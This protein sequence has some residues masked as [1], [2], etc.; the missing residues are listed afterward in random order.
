[1]L[2]AKQKKE[3]TGTTKKWLET[4][5]IGL[6]L[7]PFAK[8]PYLRGG[9]RLTVEEA[10]SM[11]K[12]LQIFADEVAFLQKNPATDT[13]LLI[14][15]GLGNIQQFQT[16]MQSCEEMLHEKKWLFDIMIVPFHPLMRFAG[17]PPDSVENTT[18]IAPFPI[19]H[20]LR[21]AQVASLGAMMKK[22]VIEAND[23]KLRS[24]SKEEIKK[25]WEKV[26]RG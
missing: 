24:M 5:I 21:Q 2:T 13:T 9:V 20:L 7:C 19:V 6:N 4:F 14:L 3:I 12:Y 25:L 26:L 16:Y 18:G 17:L 22:D 11:K 23:E 8:A 15:P 1:M 10:D